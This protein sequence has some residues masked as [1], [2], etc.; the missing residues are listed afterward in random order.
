LPEVR[1]VA[2]LHVLVIG[3]TGLQGGAVVR[4]L[5]RAGHNVRAHVRSLAH[6]E[7]ELLRLRGARLAWVDPDDEARIRDAMDGVDAVF[8]ATTASDGGPAAEARRGLLLVEAA[9]SVGVPHFVLSSIMAPG[10]STGDPLQESMLEVQRYLGTVGLP[11]T[12]IR[13]GFFM[14][15]LLSAWFGAALR[16]GRLPL[17]VPGGR[18]LQQLALQDL[19][20]FARL[21]ME[22]RSE[23]INRSIC[24][25]SDELT[26]LEMAA[27][28]ARILGR[29]VQ[30]VATANPPQH[31]SLSPLYELLER[32]GGCADVASLRRDYPEV[33]WHTLDGWA[34]RQT[35]GQD[36]R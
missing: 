4:T 7:A 24:V 1:E 34:K 26:P 10:H 14:E 27:T 15:N 20:R 33:N 31:A 3:S 22:R 35:W 18:K 23:F 30:H 29:T 6:P 12:V 25:A 28:L 2:K 13:A 17:P 32:Q 5:L 9:R 16:D 36:A 19:A 11:H 21:V 8:A